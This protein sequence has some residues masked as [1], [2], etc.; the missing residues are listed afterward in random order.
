MDKSRK[1]AAEWL[2]AASTRT[3]V[4]LALTSVAMCSLCVTNDCTSMQFDAIYGPGVAPAP[5]I[6]S[7]GGNN[8][9]TPPADPQNPPPVPL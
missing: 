1:P 9:P 6:A 3:N 8:A 5:S 2:I 7:P 4:L